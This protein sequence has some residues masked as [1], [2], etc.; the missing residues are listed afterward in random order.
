[1]C[2]YFSPL[3]TKSP[4]KYAGCETKGQ[5]CCCAVQRKVGH[6]V[7]LVCGGALVCLC[8]VC[9]WLCGCGRVS[10]L[11]CVCGVCVCVCVVLTWGES[12]VE[13]VYADVHVCVFVHT[14]VAV[15]VDVC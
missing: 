6:L 4:L 14:D 11:V 9:V 1:M 13:T 7:T 12:N 15:Y 5:S 3:K 2:S 8:G 10:V